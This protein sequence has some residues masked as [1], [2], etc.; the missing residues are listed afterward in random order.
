MQLTALKKTEYSLWK[1]PPKFCSSTTSLHKNGFGLA[2]LQHNSSLIV[3]PWPQTGLVYIDL[4]LVIIPQLP[5]KIWTQKEP[6]ISQKWAKISNY[7]PINHKNHYNKVFKPKIVH[8]QS[9]TPFCRAYGHKQ[10][11]MWPSAYP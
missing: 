3:L 4:K 7:R 6:N 2:L 1:W 10:R 5:P 8:R 9:T 11:A